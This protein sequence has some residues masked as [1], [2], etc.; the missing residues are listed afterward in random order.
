M[1]GIKAKSILTPVLLLIFAA[2]WPVK[3]IKAQD[4]QTTTRNIY[5]SG[6]AEVRVPPDE[7]DITLGV[8]TNDKDLLTA[9]R[10]N[11]ERI[12]SLFEIAKAAGVPPEYIQTDYLNIQ[13]RYQGILGA[14]KAL[15]LI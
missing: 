7:V 13:P 4:K 15:G 1:T 11:D 6:E 14:L 5:V 9:K 10:L 12:Q 2:G 3:T 8:E